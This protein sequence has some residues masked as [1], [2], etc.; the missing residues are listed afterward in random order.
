MMTEI[1]LAVAAGVFVLTLL[2]VAAL[3]LARHEIPQWLGCVAALMIAVYTLVCIALLML[4]LLRLLEMAV[5]LWIL[6][7]G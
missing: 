7:A 4:P 2:A 6:L 5:M 3:L 1:A